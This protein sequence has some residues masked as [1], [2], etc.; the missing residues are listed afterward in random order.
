MNTSAHIPVLLEPTLAALNIRPDGVYMDCTFGRGGHSQQILQRL[1]PK[2]R[3]IA[4]DQDPQ[5]IAHAEKEFANEPRLQIHHCSYRSFLHVLEDEMLEGKL[6]GL[7][8]DLGVS[9]PQLDEAERGFSF[10]KDG[11][12]DM[13]MN[14]SS[15]VTAAQWLQSAKEQ[16]IANVIYQYGEERFSRRI[17][18]AIVTARQLK[19]LQ[20]TSQ[21]AEIVKAAIP[22]WEKDKHPATRT[23]QAIRIYINNE[24]SDL[25]EA[26]DQVVEA[27]KPGGRLAVI[28]FHSLE[29]RLV[30]RFIRDEATGDPF[31]ADLPIR[32]S[33]LQRRLKLIGKAI[34]A[35][36]SELEQNPRARSAVLRVAE[37]LAV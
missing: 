15:G 16:Q 19:P 36:A 6:D 11:P 5:A 4:I 9:S 28:S 31:P 37:R 10:Q 7:L 27:L 30:K 32:D 8:F 26:L 33:D 20:G 23:F 25:E 13:R 29:D 18:R 22:K 3:L 17:A 24:L 1:G 2:G 34:R 12:L 14:T 21:L 35:N